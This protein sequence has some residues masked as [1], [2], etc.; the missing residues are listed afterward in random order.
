MRM[1]AAGFVICI[2]CTAIT[3]ILASNFGK[4]D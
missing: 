2:V 4:W 1:F 3:F